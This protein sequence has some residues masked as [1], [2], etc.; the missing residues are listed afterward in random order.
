[1]A[2]EGIL[3][4]AREECWS[5]VSPSYEAGYLQ[6]PCQNNTIVNLLDT[7]ILLKLLS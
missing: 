5:T 4:A 3:G 6:M 7:V 1:M 2:L